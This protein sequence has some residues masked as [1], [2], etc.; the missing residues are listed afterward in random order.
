MS[1]ADLS[2]RTEAATARLLGAG[3]VNSSVYGVHEA[4]LPREVT[5]SS[6]EEA[7]KV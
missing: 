6:E 3:V 4:L 1:E 5:V 7:E 2:Q